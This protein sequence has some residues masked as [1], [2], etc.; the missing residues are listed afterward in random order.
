MEYCFSGG[1]WGAVFAVPQSVVDNYIKLANE[2]SL[3]VLLFVLRNSGKKFL[4]EEIAAALNLRED[5]VEEAFIF[6]ENANIFSNNSVHEAVSR[7]PEVIS[8][9]KSE[10]PSKRVRKKSI[11]SGTGYNITPSEIADR[12]KGSEEI[13]GMFFM[14]EKSFGRP[15]NHTE[16]RSY[17]YMHDYLGMPADVILTVTAYCISIEK[18]SIS[19]IETLV[20][21]WSEKGINTLELVQEEIKEQEEKHSFNGRIA[22]AFGMKRLPTEKQQGYIDSWKSKGYSLELIEYAGE[23]TIEAIDKISF[24]YINKILENWYAQGL[25]TKSKI[26]NEQAARKKNTYDDSEHS[27]DLNDFKS[28]VN[29]FGDK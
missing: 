3:K 5:Q 29:N 24:P 22:K 2:A 17:I 11:A 7:S 13:K 19:Y 10:E 18:D 21:D 14:A 8:P 23:K 25:I 26:D 28:L 12:V 20:R 15:L 1:C 16:Q 6:W 27:Y 4:S 9:K